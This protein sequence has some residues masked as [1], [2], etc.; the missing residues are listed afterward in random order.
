M[1]DWAGLSADGEIDVDGAQA[2]AR[3]YKPAG[4]CVTTA[5][6]LFVA[7]DSAESPLRKVDLKTRTVST[8]AY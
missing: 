5:G 3:L 2:Q 4:L 1:T 7:P 8:W 6:A